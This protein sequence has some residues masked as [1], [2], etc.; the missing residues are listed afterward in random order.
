[1][2]G[3]ILMLIDDEAGTG[4]DVD[5]TL[6]GV[7]VVFNATGQSVTTTVEGLSGRVFKLHEAQATG[8]DSVVKGASFDPKKGS[9]TVPARTVA[10][11]TQATGDRIDPNPGPAQDPETA[12]WI[13]SGDGRWWLRYADG[14]YP[15]SERVVRGSSTYSFDA[16][17][18]MKTGWHIEDG[19][20][21]YY[22]PSGAMA[23][24]W[25]AVGG[26]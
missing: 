5:A 1:M 19:V 22:G 3:T 14:S 13:A 10:V 6:D 25:T 24:A 12:V 7:L 8:A 2:D 16:E 18:W 4:D 15:V 23:T 20:W 26:S 21:R 17:G 11:F 9:V